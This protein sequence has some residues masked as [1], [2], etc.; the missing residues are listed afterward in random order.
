MAR[1]TV[2]PPLLPPRTTS[3]RTIP[4]PGTIIWRRLWGKINL[5]PP[6]LK[7]EGRTM[8]STRHRQATSHRQTIPQTLQEPEG[9]AA[10]VATSSRYTGGHSS[11][12]SSRRHPSPPPA[13]RNREGSA[14]HR[15]KDPPLAPGERRAFKRIEE[16]IRG[17]QQTLRQARKEPFHQGK[18]AVQGE[19]RGAE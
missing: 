1:D 9:I 19:S 3:A 16:Q 5:F 11:H 8:V 7:A 4:E 15:H 14:T 17:L 2:A 13:S 6:P 18:H 10:T 12:H